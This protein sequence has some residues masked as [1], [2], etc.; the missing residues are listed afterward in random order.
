MYLENKTF[1]PNGDSYQDFLTLLF[2]LDKPGY[3]ATVQIFDGRGQLKKTLANNQLLGAQDFILW[4]GLVD[5]GGRG[6]VGI[7]ILNCKVFHPD[8]DIKSKKLV[9]VLADYLD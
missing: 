5:S 4:D 2:D 8:G 6:N 1:S 7:Y 9:T 3:L